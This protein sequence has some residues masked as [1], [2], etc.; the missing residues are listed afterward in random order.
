MVGI[1]EIFIVTDLPAS[2]EEG[3][4]DAHQSYLII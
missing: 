2:L 3:V 4:R 1:R